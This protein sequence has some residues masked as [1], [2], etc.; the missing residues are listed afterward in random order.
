MNESVTEMELLNAE[1]ILAAY[2]TFSSIRGNSSFAFASDAFNELSALSFEMSCAAAIP[3][4]K[5][6]LARTNIFFSRKERGLPRLRET[7]LFSVKATSSS[8]PVRK[9]S[10][11]SLKRCFQS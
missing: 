11:F 4:T 6:Y 9:R 8:D 2:L 1:Q 5:R 7:R 10:E 3:L